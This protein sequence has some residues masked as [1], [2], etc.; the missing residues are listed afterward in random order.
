MNKRFLAIAAGVLAFFI[1]LGVGVLAGG[2][3]A[4]LTFKIQ[5]IQAALALQGPNPDF[6]SGV[7][8]SGVDAEGPAAESGVVRGDILISLDD[9]PID[10]F[11]ALQS[12]LAGANPGDTLRLSVL[13]GD[14]TRTL[15]VTL[16]DRNGNAY[17]G[18]V[19]CL[20]STGDR[21][22][23]QP[24]LE[25]PAIG[26]TFGAQITEV[27]SGTPA[28]EAGLTAGDVI[29]GV[30]GHEV[31]P[32]VNLADLI[33]GY[34][35]NDTLELSVLKASSSEPVDVTVTLGE[36]P[37]NPGQAYLGIYYTYR[38]QRNEGIP[39]IQ[40]PEGD[41]ANP[42]GQLPDQDRERSPFEGLPFGQIMPS[43][44]EGL[45]QA[46]L[47]SEVIPGSP[48]EQA[49]MQA[50]DLI[51]AVNGDPVSEAEALVNIVKSLEPGDRLELTVYR[52]NSTSSST[53]EVALG[54]NP[55]QA[56]AAYLGVR[57]GTVS[58]SLP[59]GHPP[60]NPMPTPDNN[61]SSSPNLSGGGDA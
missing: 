21:G 22:Q 61:G 34:Q 24:N 37:D 9:K 8:V 18:I 1:V 35:P 13:H 7:L 27:I 57:I 33:Q 5:P 44:P 28:D 29:V 6:D 30:D 25:N 36:N 46:V 26:A 16:T 60:I 20:P 38:M 56:G 58:N 15:S 47:V 32:E 50:G 2:T 49:G 53:I 52:A 12:I 23:F 4:Y 42:F 31:N 48:A 39:F 41:E 55:G 43:L 19:P 40:P 17:L 14:E 11:Q 45:S 3:I 51:T 10:S 59:E 54:E